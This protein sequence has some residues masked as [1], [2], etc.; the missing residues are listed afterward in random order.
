MLT[1][2]AAGRP[3]LEARQESPK[4]AGPPEAKAANANAE[5]PADLPHAIG[6]DEE[7]RPQDRRPKNPPPAGMYSTKA[8]AVKAI[9]KLFEAYDFKPHGQPPVPDDPPPHEGAMIDYPIVIQPPDLLLVEVLEALPGR[10]ISGERLVKPDGTVS[11]SW[12]GDVHVAGLTVEQARVKIIRHLRTHLSDDGLGLLQSSPWE[13]DDSLP[14]SAAGG[15]PPAPAPPADADPARKPEAGAS[16]GISGPPARNIRRTSQAGEGRRAEP[17]QPSRRPAKAAVGRF[18]ASHQEPDEK[19]AEDSSKRVEVPLSAGEKAT[20]TITIDVKSEGKPA[21]PKEE[22][23]PKVRD[24]PDDPDSESQGGIRVFPPE[25]SKQ[26]F[27][28]VTRYEADNYFVLG[29]VAAP[30]R[31]PCTGRET[32]LDALQYG[33]GLLPTADPKDIRLVRPARGGKPAKVYKVDLE[34]IRDRGE[35]TLNYQIFSGDRLVVGRDG[36]VQK[37]VQLD[38]LAA[39]LSTIS[40]AILREA[41]ALRSIQTLDPARRDA[42]MRGLVD[43]WSREMTRPEGAKI[44]DAILRDVLL[45]AFEVNPNEAKPK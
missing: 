38:R 33:G 24:L 35:I 44:D 30:G 19:K 18:V 7:S 12:Y 34:G 3:A 25:S 5:K 4:P 32:V 45:K 16:K 11:L 36:T 37:T 39:P 13:E 21:Q 20:I 42:I 22:D 9:D 40:D 41:N 43:F 26:V 27:V 10:P 29:D 23:A 31:L 17:R 8:E 15:S 1:L 6:A 2:A 28:D 14:S